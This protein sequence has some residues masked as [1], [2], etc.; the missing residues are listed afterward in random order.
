[1]HL[2]T[3][4]IKV[5]TIIFIKQKQNLDKIFVKFLFFIKVKLTNKAD[6]DIN[7]KIR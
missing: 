7:V 6:P 2:I 4:Q 3:K 1:M 5:V